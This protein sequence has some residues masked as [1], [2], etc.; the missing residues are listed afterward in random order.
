MSMRVATKDINIGSSH[1]AGPAVYERNGREAR[2]ALEDREG[3]RTECA[4]DEIRISFADDERDITH[5]VGNARWR[6]SDIGNK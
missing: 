3:R 2:T 4:P 1:D 6:R 5:G